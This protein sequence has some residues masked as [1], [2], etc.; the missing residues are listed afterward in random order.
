MQ[1][2]TKLALQFSLIVGIIL[3]LF[4]IA[5]YYFSAKYR[6]QEFYSRLKEKALTTAKF[7]SKDVQEIN[8]RLL[9]IIDSNFINAL[10]DERI[11][12]YD[13]SHNQLYSSNDDSL[14]YPKDFLI[15]IRLQKEIKYMEGHTEVLGLV[16]E[17]KYDRYVVIASAFDKYGRSKLKFLGILVIT[18]FFISIGITILTGLFYSKQAL[19]PIANVVKQVENITASNLDSRVHEGNGTDE[20]ARLAI[21]FNQM[22]ERLETSFEMQRSFVANASHELRTPLTAITGQIEVSL[23]SQKINEEAKIVLKSLLEDI[24]NLNKLSN[25]LLDLAQANLDISEIKLSVLRIDELI[26]Q[27]TAELLKRNKDYSVNIEFEEFPEDEGKVRLI[28]NEQLLK[29]AIKNIIE[30]A[31]KY[32]KNKEADLKIRFQEN[33]IFLRVADDGIGIPE[34][35]IALI[36]EPFYRADNARSYSGNG[37]GL[38]LTQKIIQLHKGQIRIKSQENKGTLVSII[39]P[40]QQNQLFS[41]YLSRD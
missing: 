1:I 31:C 40:N 39:L 21:E 38:T 24:R 20:I 12:I 4:S 5:I 17:G 8:P 37:I 13:Y 18:G 15:K 41:N 30:N 29:V 35:D 32:S 9:K 7:L 25:G 11:V 34:K 14:K 28:G 26:G 23:M 16:F 2:R 3:I 22:L 33:K 36:F 27:A 19:R 10:P 6:Q